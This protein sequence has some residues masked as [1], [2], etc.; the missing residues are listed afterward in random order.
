MENSSFG[1]G[2]SIFLNSTGYSAT[3]ALEDV[4]DSGFCSAYN[5]VQNG[6]ETLC[7]QLM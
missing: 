4:V 2:N 5:G 1:S 3:S 7:N 6:S